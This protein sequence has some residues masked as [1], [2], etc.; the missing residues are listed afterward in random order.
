MT[1]E[2]PETPKMPD[3]SE[4][5]APED[6]QEI[7]IVDDLDDGARGSLLE[8]VE[9]SAQPEEAADDAPPQ[10]EAARLRVELLRSREA[11]AEARERQLRALA[12]YEN[13]RRRTQR[14]KDEFSRNVL[15]NFLREILPV[16]DN[17]EAALAAPAAPGSAPPAEQPDHFRAG[18]E[19]IARQM[20]DV[21]SR[22][23]LSEVPGEG[24]EFDPALHEAVARRETTESPANTVVR[25]MR[26][27]YLIH[28]R[29]LRAALVEVAV[30]PEAES[31]Q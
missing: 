15:G 13:L 18:I 5:E 1:A 8:E 14:E 4:N 20:R 7:L 26:K 10:G 28:D 3:P 30:R 24:A 27:G 17:L 16:V 23:G 25:V 19:L 22:M 29:L 31:P 6:E 21:L 2:D 12:D 11:E 9:G